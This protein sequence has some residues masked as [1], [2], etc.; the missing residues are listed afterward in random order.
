MLSAPRPCLLT[1]S[2]LELGLEGGHQEGARGTA[3]NE[4]ETSSEVNGGD[5]GGAGEDGAEGRDDPERGVRRHRAEQPV[6]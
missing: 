5:R 1:G 6:A 3:P 4:V 2:D